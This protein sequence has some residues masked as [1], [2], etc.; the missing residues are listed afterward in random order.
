MSGVLHHS[1]LCSICRKNIITT[2][3]NCTKNSLKAAEGNT[4]LMTLLW[5]LD[6]SA[7]DSDLELDAAPRGRKAASSY[8]KQ[9]S[10]ERKK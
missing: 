5:C 1:H 2:F 6:F 4:L 10:K 7:L 9:K 3:H 8:K